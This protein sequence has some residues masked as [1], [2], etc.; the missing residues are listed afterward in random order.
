MTKGRSTPWYPN[1][2]TYKVTDDQGKPVNVAAS[3]EDNRLTFQIKD[4]ALNGKILKI[5]ITQK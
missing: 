2:Y 5:K 1:G 4:Q 3:T